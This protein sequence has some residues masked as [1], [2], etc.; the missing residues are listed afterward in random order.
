MELLGM[1]DSGDRSFTQYLLTQGDPGAV[2]KT[3]SLLARQTLKPGL[4]DASCAY[5]ENDL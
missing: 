4:F 3:L 1:D 2:Y 5:P